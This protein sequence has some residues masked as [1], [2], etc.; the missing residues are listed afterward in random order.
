MIFFGLC[1]RY[2][3][4]KENLVSNIERFIEKPDKERAEDFVK[5]KRFTWNSGMFLF[6]SKVI[7]NEIEKLFNS[8]F[9]EES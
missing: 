4:T 8:K 9:G 5:D 7:L 6:K 3:V 1:L 2:H